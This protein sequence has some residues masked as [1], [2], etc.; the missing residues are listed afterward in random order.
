[1]KPSEAKD[2]YSIDQLNEQ[3]LKYNEEAFTLRSN[4]VVYSKPG[5]EVSIPRHLFERFI[6]WYQ[7]DQ[8]C[9]DLDHITST[10][11]ACGAKYLKGAMCPYCFGR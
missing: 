10:C 2:Q 6:D 8:V 3:G 7:E 11:A 1:M 4:V 5:L 9:R